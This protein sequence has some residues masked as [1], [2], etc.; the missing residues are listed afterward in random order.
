MSD[1]RTGMIVLHPRNDRI[2]RSTEVS[3]LEMSKTNGQPSVKIQYPREEARRARPF[4]GFARRCSIANKCWRAYGADSHTPRSEHSAAT[5][6]YRAY[7]SPSPSRSVA[8]KFEIRRRRVGM[9]IEIQCAEATDEITREIWL[10]A[11]YTYE[12]RW[13]MSNC[14]DLSHSRPVL[15]FSRWHVVFLT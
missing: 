2:D 15:L 11:K 13:R 10:A 12:C 4:I 8:E 7:T 5:Y 3:S 14:Q 1:G 9:R 6:R